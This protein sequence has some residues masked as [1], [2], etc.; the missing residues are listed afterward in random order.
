MLLTMAW[1]TSL[2]LDGC[3]YVRLTGPAVETLTKSKIYP[4]A[5]IGFH[6]YR[7]PTFFSEYQ[8]WEIRFSD[9]CVRYD[10]FDMSS[11]STTTTLIEEKGGN[12]IATV[13]GDERFIDP[14]VGFFWSLGKM[15]HQLAII[16]GGTAALFL[17]VPCICL[18]YSERT[19]KIG[20]MILLLAAFFH[21]FS[22][23]WFFN[24]L[25]MERGS[26]CHWFYGSYS[27]L[28]S[29]VLYMISFACVFIKYPKPVVVKLI[30][31]RI[32]E[33]FQTRNRPGFA[34]D[35]STVTHLTEVDNGSSA[36]SQIS[37]TSDQ[38]INAIR[39]SPTTQR[40]RS[41]INAFGLEQ[42]EII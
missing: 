35:T 6:S 2:S 13:M 32:E 20:G 15:S 19:W 1:M 11:S 10:L 41:R 24:I 26:K 8:S 21:F 29:F 7:V 16:M 34:R 39:I 42:H 12:T 5:E 31:K 33:D 14:T 22:M 9:P 4:Y 36:W 23:I 38:F 25:C 37:H 18:S 27:T 40:Q 3:D 28:A 30:Q 17:W